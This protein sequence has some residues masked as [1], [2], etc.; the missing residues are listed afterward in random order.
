MEN[1]ASSKMFMSLLNAAPNG[2]IFG[3]RIITNFL[4]ILKVKKSLKT[5]QYLMKLQGV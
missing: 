1:E 3:D 2:G 5:G 4:P